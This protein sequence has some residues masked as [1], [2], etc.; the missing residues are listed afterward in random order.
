MLNENIPMYLFHQ[1][2]NAK[3]YEYLGSHR[4][5]EDENFTFFRVWAPHAVAVFVACDKNE[6]TG[7]GFEL[8]RINEQG[9]WEGR[10]EGF[11]DY[12]AYKYLIIAQD[13]RKLMKCDPYAFHAETRPGTASKIYELGSFE[14]TD[15][16]WL[17]KRRRKNIYSSPVNIYELHVGSWQRYPDG[18]TLSY[19]ELADRLVPY[20]LDMGYTHIELLPI[21]EHPFDG[22]WGYQVTG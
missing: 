11:K 7:E 4:D 10:F 22:S 18:N 19:R 21:M 5:E 8:K 17:K 13:G 2:T 20:V 1:G 3:A 15:G 9:L 14:W 12:D 16:A 6:W